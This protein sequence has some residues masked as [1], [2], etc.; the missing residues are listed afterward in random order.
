MLVDEL[1][2]SPSLWH[3]FPMAAV[4][5]LRPSGSKE[6]PERG[7]R[8]NR[9]QV[10][11][12]RLTSYGAVC[13]FNSTAMLPATYPHILAFPL[14]MALMTDARCPFPLLGLVHIGNRIQQFKRIHRDSVLDLECRFGSLIAHEKGT[15][16]SIDTVAS[17]AGERV[18]SSQ[19]IMLHR[20]RSANKMRTS[21]KTGSRHPSAAESMETW[22]LDKNTGLRYAQISGDYNPIHLHPLTAR[23]FGFPR[24]IAHGMWTK[25]RCL[26]ALEEQLPPAFEVDVQFKLPIL[27]PACVSLNYTQQDETLN[28]S[29]SD[30][31]NG[32]PHLSGR[33]LALA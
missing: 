30:C 19:S 24:A 31:K 27:L 6:L 20:E 10:H 17:I 28:F 9:I 25:A 12:R 5:S 18:W 21:G 26:A 1:D 3:L 7:I 11:H 8:L 16:F 33:I 13:G 4:R 2:Q 29:V 15:A 23:L 22:T 14:H 32:S